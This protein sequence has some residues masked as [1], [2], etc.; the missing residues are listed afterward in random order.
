MSETP[1]HSAVLTAPRFHFSPSIGGLNNVRPLPAHS[2]R[3]VVVRD[4]IRRMY[5]EPG[6]VTGVA[7]AAPNHPG[8]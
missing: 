1:I 6:E 3:A 8:R 5:G 7:T 4:G 2:M